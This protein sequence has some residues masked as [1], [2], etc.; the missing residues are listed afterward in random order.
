MI[1]S[2]GSI[3]RTT[4][5]IF[6]AVIFLFFFFKFLPVIILIGIAFYVI[7]KAIGAFKNWKSSNEYN[8]FS[9]EKS[10]EDFKN[11]YEFTDKK[12]IDVD[13]YDVDK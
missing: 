12:I 3:T 7:F 1:K 5:I 6:L 8:S 2:L 10:Q 4:L 13:Y 11:N 9:K